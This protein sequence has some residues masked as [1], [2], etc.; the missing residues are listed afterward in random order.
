M[1]APSRYGQLR[2]GVGRY[3]GYGLFVIRRP[4]V[5]SQ[6]G[7]AALGVIEGGRAAVPSLAVAVL[8]ATVGG[9]AAAPGHGGGPIRVIIGEGQG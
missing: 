8:R 3:G 4:Q 9:R 2:Y 1:S 7:G 6:P 5:V